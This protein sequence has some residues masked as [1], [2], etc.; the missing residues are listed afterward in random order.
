[1]GMLLI[2]MLMFGQQAFAAKAVVLIKAITR[3]SG[4]PC[5]VFDAI[6]RSSESLVNSESVI[7]DPVNQTQTQ[8]QTAIRNQAAVKVNEADPSLQLVGSDFNV[9]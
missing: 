4:Q 1:M 9:I 5:V 6:G 8:M 3:C 2:G 7:V